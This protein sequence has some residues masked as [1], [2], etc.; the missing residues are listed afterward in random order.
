MLFLLEAGI[1]LHTQT[2]MDWKEEVGREI[3]TN[4]N[5]IV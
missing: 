1:G 2:Q 5:P 3:P 4:N